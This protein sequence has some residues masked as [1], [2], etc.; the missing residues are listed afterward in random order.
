M[1]I[2]T[3]FG[4]KKTFILLI[5]F[6][7]VFI[8]FFFRVS[9][10]IEAL[11][12]NR[13]DLLVE[14]GEGLNL[15][16]NSVIKENKLYT[17]DGVII[18]SIGIS[19]T[20]ASL[21]HRIENRIN[22][23]NVIVFEFDD[24]NIFSLYADIEDELKPINSN[25]AMLESNSNFVINTNFYSKS[26]KTIGELIINGKSYSK[27]SKNVSGFFKVIN[28]RPHVGAKS[29]FRN[30][31]GKIQYSCQAFPSVMKGGNIWSYIMSEKGA[32]KLSWKKKK[33]RNLIGTKPNGNLVLLVSNTGALLT[34]KEI[35][36][37]AKNIGIVNASLF[38]GGSAL[39]YK[40]RDSK[41]SLSFSVLNNS[42]SL[43]SN[44]NDFFYEYTGINFIQKSPVFLAIKNKTII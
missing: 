12:D 4:I 10:N 25:T 29:L 15:L 8:A 7:M 30:K 44:F 27:K 14:T 16:S 32:S 31:K 20:E 2:K 11:L 9:T 36:M 5:V 6:F 18:S 41:F 23:N 21:F 38:D 26:N 13:G 28:G 40:Y 3:S 42:L 43:G 39:Q 37:I 35:S 1:K 17:A 33:Y 22:P 34:V 24:N 19:R